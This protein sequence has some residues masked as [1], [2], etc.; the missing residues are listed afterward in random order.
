MTVTPRLPDD[1]V[2]VS[3]THPLA[4]AGTLVAGVSLIFVVVTL[5]AVFAIDILL[6]L[7][8]PATEARWLSNLSPELQ[9]EDTAE[10]RDLEALLRRL[11]RHWET[12]YDFS[13]RHR[14]DA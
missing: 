7:V 1:T 10:Q 5:L 12:D 3:D 14:P 4:E 6:R 11:E 8:S 9:I 13:H 2:N